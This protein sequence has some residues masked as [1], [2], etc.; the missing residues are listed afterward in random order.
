MR[1][2]L[3]FLPQPLFEETNGNFA[4]GAAFPSRFDFHFT[5]E[6]IGN[7]KGS[8]HKAS[9]LYCWV[10]CKGRILFLPSVFSVFRL[11]GQRCSGRAEF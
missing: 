11:S 7:L 8:F 4:H 10:K 6:V 3:F 1:R 9:L 2:L 5:V